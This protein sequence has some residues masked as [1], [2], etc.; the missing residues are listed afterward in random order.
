[1]RKF[2]AHY[3]IPHHTN[4]F[5]AKF[6]HHKILSVLI[7]FF[8]LSGFLFQFLQTNYPTVLGVYSD[9]SIE[10]L[11]LLT[12]QKRSENGAPPL[13]IDQ[14]LSQAAAGK[15]MD[16]F[17]E[18]YWAHNSPSGKTPWVFIKG[19]GYNYV[20]AGENLAKGYS[21]ASDVVSA[22][23][24]SPD[25]RKN[26]L[27]QNYK[28]IGFAIEKGRL[29][30]E[31]TILI[32]EMFGN[33][34]QRAVASTEVVSN[35]PQEEVPPT[36]VNN[37][38]PAVVNVPTV[39][40][41]PSPVQVEANDKKILVA[42]INKPPIIN[43]NSTTKNVALFVVIF[44]ISLFFLDIIIVEKRNIVRSF[45]HHIDHVMFLT[46]VLILVIVMFQGSII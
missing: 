22:W 12:N 19:A 26:M 6:L 17:S 24:N 20:F 3:F 38:T 9:I 45:K 23:M 11:V 39:T 15:A 34:G 41:A 30:G 5:K 14:R 27:S 10:E 35:Q 29:N 32:V 2:L 36:T 43:T 1:M 40:L 16:M 21:S 44:L 31:E 18:N 33:S 28:D 25:H 13:V 8:V 46:L 42:G 4:N 7:L 37:P